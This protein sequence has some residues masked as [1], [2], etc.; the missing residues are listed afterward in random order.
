MQV[1]TDV[2]LELTAF[3]LS[4]TQL[5]AEQTLG[6]D[7]YWRTLV[8]QQ[9]NYHAR[10]SL[11]DL[12][13][14]ERVFQSEFQ[15]PAGFSIQRWLTNLY[16]L[17]QHNFDLPDNIQPAQYGI[18]IEVFECE[19]SSQCQDASRLTFFDSQGVQIGQEVLLPTII[20]I[21]AG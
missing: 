14:L 3:S 20:T 15:Q 7:L 19:Q 1:R 17:D 21:T 10:I 2:G 4:Q 9:E 12:S 16:V 6:F 18:N 13:S 5:T 11:V 8:P